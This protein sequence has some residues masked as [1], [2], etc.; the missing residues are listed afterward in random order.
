MKMAARS[1]ISR[2]QQQSNNKPTT[3][4]TDDHKP[5]PKTSPVEEPKPTTTSTTTG[6]H[7]KP[8]A[9]PILYEAGTEKL[10]DVEFP[11]EKLIKMITEETA[12][13]KGDD[14]QALMKWAATNNKG[15]VQSHSDEITVWVQKVVLR[16]NGYNEEE[17]TRREYL[18]CCEIFAQKHPEKVKEIGAPHLAYNNFS[19]ESQAGQ[20]LDKAMKLCTSE[21]RELDLGTVLGGS[22]L[23]EG[24]T[25][26]RK[27]TVLIT[28]SLT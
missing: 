21:G 17:I 6:G 3:T 1:T 12:I 5:E 11:D 18:R 26:K 10:T 4:T 15:E 14:F 27:Y 16:K 7:K 24:D 8:K 2:Q 9:L 22:W 19:D 13:R 20:H 25:S 28:G 23:S